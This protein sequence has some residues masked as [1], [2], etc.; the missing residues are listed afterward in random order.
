MPDR[1][2]GELAVLPLYPG[3]GPVGDRGLLFGQLHQP[4]NVAKYGMISS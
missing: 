3:H 1:L 2:T 4:P